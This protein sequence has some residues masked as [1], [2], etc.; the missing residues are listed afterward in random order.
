MKQIISDAEQYKTTRLFRNYKGKYVKKAKYA[1]LYGMSRSL[2]IKKAT[3]GRKNLSLRVIKVLFKL[4][5]T[6]P[7]EPNDPARAK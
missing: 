1:L 4:S 5:V 3:I 7:F 2:L 6:S